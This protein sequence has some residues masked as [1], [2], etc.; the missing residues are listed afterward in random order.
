[1]RR[2][3]TWAAGAVM[4]LCWAPVVLAAYRHGGLAS[5]A[6]AAILGWLIAAAF[7]RPDEPPDSG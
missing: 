2:A 7:I 5:G 1:M 6:V 4:L 3:L